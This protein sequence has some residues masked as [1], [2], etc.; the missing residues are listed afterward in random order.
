M[1]M[2]KTPVLCCSVLLVFVAANS[3]CRAAVALTDNPE[4]NKKQYEAAL[5]LRQNLD[6]IS[7]KAKQE[8]Q[9]AKL[10]S[11]AHLMAMRKPAPAV[12]AP[13]VQARIEAAVSG[14]RSSKWIYIG[15]VFAV[16]AA[17]VGGVWVLTKRSAAARE[18]EN[19]YSFRRAAQVAKPKNANE[20][21]R[22]YFD[23]KMQGA[24]ERKP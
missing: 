5:Q 16:F 11:D 15:S 20:T 24:Q 17:A 23:K 18:K 14:N 13:E 10:I 19:N 12:L 21:V 9:K 7:T 4:E 3:S 6:A 22:D 8:A 2:K 1:T